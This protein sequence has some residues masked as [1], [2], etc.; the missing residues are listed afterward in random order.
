L[1]WRSRRRAKP[2][3]R[4]HE[5]AQDSEKT[6]PEASSVHRIESGDLEATAEAVAKYEATQERAAESDEKLFNLLSKISVP[7]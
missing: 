5:G 2:G 1:R 4:L 7:E 6:V 3:Q